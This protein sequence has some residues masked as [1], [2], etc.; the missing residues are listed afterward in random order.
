M[1]R[2]VTP[3]SG[4]EPPESTRDTS[5][6]T[7][8][9]T[10]ELFPKASRVATTGGVASGAPTVPLPGWIAKASC[11]AEAGATAIAVDEVLVRLP[12]VNAI[13]ILVATLWQRFVND[14]RPS[15][16]V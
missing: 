7:P 3:P 15:A 10:V 13:V 6:V 4:P 1:S 2:L 9:P 16:A 5:L 8:E 12:L 14:T 11:A